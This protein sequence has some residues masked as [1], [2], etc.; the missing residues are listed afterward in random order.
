MFLWLWRQNECKP[1]SAGFASRPL[2]YIFIITLQ[3][4]A[5]VMQL[6]SL[7]SSLAIHPS[8]SQWM[9]H[10]NIKRPEHKPETKAAM[11]VLL[12][13]LLKEITP[14]IKARCHFIRAVCVCVYTVHQ[15]VGGGMCFDSHH[16]HPPGS[17][18]LLWPLLLQCKPLDGDV[19]EG[20]SEEN[21]CGEH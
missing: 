9:K 14:A 6:S 15:S 11:W 3:Q 20:Q 5:C 17:M 12:L 18:R 8:A 10:V 2:L 13:W 7:Q 21:T 19:R 4:M 1:H 16:P